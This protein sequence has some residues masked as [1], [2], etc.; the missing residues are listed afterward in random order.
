MAQAVEGG[1]CMVCY[2][3][4]WLCGQLELNPTG[5]IWGE[6]YKPHT[7]D[8]PHMRSKETRVSI[9]SVLLLIGWGLLPHVNS[10]ALLQHAVP[11]SEVASTGFG[12]SLPGKKCKSQQ[13]EVN[14]S[15]LQWKHWTDI[16]MSRTR[17]VLQLDSSWKSATWL[18][19]A[20]S[21]MQGWNSP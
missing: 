12:G 9:H 6:K 16:S 8:L 11:G 3:T 18:T 19:F 2:K 13:S 5:Q 4:N 21:L 10:L 14:G 17:T 1:Q 7:S 15:T 20:T